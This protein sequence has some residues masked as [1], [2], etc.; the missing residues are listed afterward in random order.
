MQAERRLNA[1]KATLD[2]RERELDAANQKLREALATSAGS[3]ATIK[4]LEEAVQ[5]CAHARVQTLACS[6][7]P[8]LP[9]SLTLTHSLSHTSNL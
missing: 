1:L 2:D 5:R 3:D 9:H 6:L 7:P 8:S 4:L